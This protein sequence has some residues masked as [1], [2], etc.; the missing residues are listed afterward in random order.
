MADRVET[1]ADLYALTQEQLAEL[2]RM[3][4]K[5]AANLVQALERSKK[6]TLA[7]FLYALGIRDVGEATAAALADHFGSL[8]PLQQA[9]E[10]GIQ[11][12]PDVGPVVAAHVH[13]FFQQEHNREVIDALRER[14]VHWPAQTG[15]AARGEVPLEGKTFVITGTLDSMSRDEAERSHHRARRQGLRQRVEEDLLR[16]RRRRSRLEAQEGPGAGRGDPGR[17][18]FLALLAEARLPEAG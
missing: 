6:T 18:A 3:G 13:H 15:E 1:P 7:R 14:G 4:E 12:V 16:R 17:G 9:T 8:E 5:S 10:E 11:E 2:E